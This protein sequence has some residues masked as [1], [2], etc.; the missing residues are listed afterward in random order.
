MKRLL[1]CAAAVLSI[2]MWTPT[3]ANAAIELKL[4]HVCPATGD[5][6]EQAAQVFKK[7]V[8]EKTGG[9]IVVKTFPASQLG[10]EREMLES[11]QMGTLECGTITN[12]PF[13]NFLKE[14]LVFDIPFVFSKAEHAHRVLDGEFGQYLLGLVGC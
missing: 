9:E 8:E 13:S 11:I 4:G 14:T 6:L 10:G 1:A 2:A 5:R 3:A 12:A 7:Y